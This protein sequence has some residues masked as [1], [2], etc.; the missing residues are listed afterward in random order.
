MINK[1]Q[2]FH[3]VAQL[4]SWVCSSVV[5]LLTVN[6]SSY[7]WKHIYEK[8]RPNLLNNECS[9]GATDE[10]LFSLIDLNLK[11]KELDLCRINL[12]KIKNK[13]DKYK[14]YIEQCNA[15]GLLDNKV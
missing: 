1:A 7:I 9:V 2:L 3:I 12:N 14:K 6:F 11:N 5:E 10:V 8:S 4:I 13:N 15:S